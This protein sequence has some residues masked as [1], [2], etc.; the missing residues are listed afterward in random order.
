MVAPPT[1]VRCEGHYKT[2]ERCRREAIS[3]ATVCRIHGGAASQ[4][5]NRAAARIGNAADDM[6]KKLHGMLD[7]PEVDARDK[8]KIAQDMLDRAG[9]NMTEKHLVS[10]DV[11]PVERL[12]RDILAKPGGLAPEV[13]VAHETPAMFLEW[14][15]ATYDD[16]VVDGEIVEEPQRERREPEVETFSS[17][18]PKHI[19]EG[20]KRSEQ[21]RKLI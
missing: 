21:L 5:R 14:N 18:P 20:L 12:F 11:D 8:I 13:P 3:G 6:V 19:R 4:V 2:G 7:D 1:A 9:L 15:R 16:D 10:V 17:K